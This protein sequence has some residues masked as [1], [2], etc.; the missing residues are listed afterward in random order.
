MRTHTHTTCTRTHA[1]CT[2]TRASLHEDERHGRRVRGGSCQGVRSAPDRRLLS[3]RCATFHQRTT[4]RSVHRSIKRRRLG[5]GRPSGVS[6]SA[7]EL[8]TSR[9]CLSP[10][11]PSACTS[12]TPRSAK[13]LG[14]PAA[15]PIASTNQRACDAVFTCKT[16]TVIVDDETGSRTQ[17]RHF[18]T[19][20]RRKV[21]IF[22][23]ALRPHLPNASP[24][25]GTLSLD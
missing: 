10:S 19:C 22:T 17:N 20:L 13:N 2:Y 1:Q 21:Y 23:P 15:D 18:V 5:L 12:S 9:L 4:P 24:S 8:P 3:C 11:S 25:T 16:L 7:G 14:V 6:S